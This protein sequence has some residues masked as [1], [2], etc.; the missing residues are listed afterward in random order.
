M[1]LTLVELHVE[2]HPDRTFIG[3]IS[4]VFD[5]LGG[6]FTPTGLEASP[7]AVERR[8]ERVSR[9]DE[10]GVDLVHIGTHVRHWL[11]WASS[12]IRSLREGL[13]ERPSELVI[14]RSLG[15]L[16]M[17]RR[18]PAVAGGGGDGTTCRRTR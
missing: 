3:R 9:L 14:R 2:E 11:R 1:N 17:A 4:R 10:Q 5:F 7:P 6:T 8:V 13:S 18:L 16:G 15:R 12:G